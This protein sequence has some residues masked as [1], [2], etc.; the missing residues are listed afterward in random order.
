MINKKDSYQTTCI[1][2]ST[3][4]FFIVAHL[5][6]LLTQ[7]RLCIIVTLVTIDRI[8]HGQTILHLLC[9]NSKKLDTE[10]RRENHLGM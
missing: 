7:W 9:L 3:V 8:G 5:S 10:I 4:R 2:E 6:W 1:M